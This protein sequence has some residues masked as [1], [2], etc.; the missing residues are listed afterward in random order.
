MAANA[1]SSTAMIIAALM[2]SPLT[3][4][5]PLHL[6]LLGIFLPPDPLEV[7]YGNTGVKKS[8]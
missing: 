3:Q 4:K 1:T 8:E 7:G 2:V 5:L 6:F